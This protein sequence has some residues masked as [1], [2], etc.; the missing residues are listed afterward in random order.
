M[1]R[2]I[3]L[4]MVLILHTQAC[5]DSSAQEPRTPRAQAPAPRVD[6]TSRFVSHLE[7][8]QPGGVAIPRGM[9]L[10]NPYEGSAAA[11]AT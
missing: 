3:A 1:R 2:I 5:R 4:A 9:V 10:R 8:V 6:T 7:H 11:V